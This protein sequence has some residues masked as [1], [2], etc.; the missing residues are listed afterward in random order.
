MCGI[1]GFSLSPNE[2]NIHPGQLTDALLN[3]IV[4]RGRDAS[5]VAWVTPD[6]KNIEVVKA[7]AS[8]PDF[9]AAGGTLD[10]HPD[11]RDAIIHTRFATVGDPIDD[12]NNHPLYS[13]RIIG[14]HNGGVSNHKAMFARL[15]V[16]RRAEVDSE[17]IFALLDNTKRRPEETLG[18]LDGGIATAWYDTTKIGELYLARVRTSPVALLQTTTGSTLFAS[19][20]PMLEKVCADLNLDISWRD[21]LDPARLLRIRAGRVLDYLSIS[22]TERE[23]AVWPP[24]NYTGRTATYPTGTT[25]KAITSGPATQLSGAKSTGGG[26]VNSVK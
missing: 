18:Q 16:T 20:M 14:V 26:A 3:Q 2:K 23:K 5:G 1:A 7:D 22:G 24:S 25:S 19:E 4:T 17:A 15:G 12:D 6:Q 10:I 21:M 8:A 11:V 13:G 9:I